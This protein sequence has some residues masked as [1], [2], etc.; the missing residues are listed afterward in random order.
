MDEIKIYELKRMDLRNAAV[1]D[2]FP[3]VGLVSTITANYLIGTLQMEQIGILDSIHFPTVSVVRNSEPLNPVRIYAKE[4]V[5]ENESQVVVFISEFQPP[6]NLIKMIAGTILDW[7]MEQGCNLL[8]SPEG[9]VIDRGEGSL[10]EMK[11]ENN[12]KEVEEL[13]AY[14]IGS[15]ERARKLLSDNDIQQ[16]QEGVISG[17]AGVLLNEGKRRDFDV[18]SLLAEARPNYPDARAAARVIEAIDKVLLHM[19]IDVKPLYR[20]AEGIE[21]RIMSMQKQAKTTAKK[22]APIPQ[23]YG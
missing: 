1:I 16:F 4:K 14:G 11:D 17:V 10:D 5:K 8:I 9:L 15:T 2:G 23:M 3:S 21:A 13:E 12:E 22:K 6:P 7:M 18:I 19:N 20:E